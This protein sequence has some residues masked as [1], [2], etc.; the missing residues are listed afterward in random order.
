MRKSDN[1]G[2]RPQRSP[3]GFVFIGPAGSGKGTQATILK[4]RYSLCHLSTGD[5]LRAEV[6]AGSDIGRQAKSLMDQGKLVGDDIIVNMIREN[7]FRPECRDGF[8]LDGF[9]RTNVQ[10][11]Q[12]DNMLKANGK[13]LTSA[14]ELRVED[15]E[16]VKRL[17]GRLTHLPSGR[18]YNR[19]T[20][21]PK[22]EGKDDVTGEPLSERDDDKEET[23]RKRVAEYKSKTSPVLHYYKSKDLLCTV[24]GHQ[25]INVVTQQIEQCLS[26][27]RK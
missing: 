13:S 17:S 19:R 20:N 21:P 3:T 25:D 16:L 7:L 27:N 2:K 26:Q 9:P 24:N 5:M 4:D 11:E 8:I 6:K 14:V 22:V 15:E 18:V 12:L 1:K 10:A 23:V